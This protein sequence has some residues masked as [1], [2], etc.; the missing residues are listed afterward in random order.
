MKGLIL[1]MLIA[2][3]TTIGCVDNAC[4]QTAGADVSRKL[5]LAAAKGELSSQQILLFR[6]QI[7]E[8]NKVKASAIQRERLA[9]ISQKIDR[10]RST[11]RIAS[12]RLFGWF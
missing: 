6:Q 11:K 10:A 8:A 4:A 1:P 3:A 7:E 5:S 12:G 2:V 9:T